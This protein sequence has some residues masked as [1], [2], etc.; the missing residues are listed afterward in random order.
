MIKKMLPLQEKAN[1]YTELEL[2]LLLNNTPP[3]KEIPFVSQSYY[4]FKLHNFF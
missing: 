3:F 1:F 2:P 4:I